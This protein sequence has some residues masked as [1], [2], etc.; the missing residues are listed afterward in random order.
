MTFRLSLN[1]TD[2]RLSQ[3][4]KADLPK[5]VMELGMTMEVRL[6]HSSNELSSIVLMPFYS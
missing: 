4:L 3:C 5:E 6:V 2:V 1:V